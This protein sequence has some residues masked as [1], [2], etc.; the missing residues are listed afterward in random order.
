[1]LPLAMVMQRVIGRKSREASRCY[2]YAESKEGKA[3]LPPGWK[4]QNGMGNS[5]N[6]RC[7]GEGEGEG[8]ATPPSTAQAVF[9]GLEP[10]FPRPPP[11]DLR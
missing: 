2:A 10:P 5:R 6:A 8:R 7:C 9:Y 11:V 3:R 1:M 4:E